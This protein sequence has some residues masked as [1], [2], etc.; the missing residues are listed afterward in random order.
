MNYEED[1]RIDESALDVE[2]LNQPGLFMK[3][4]RHLA[5]TRKILDE[6]KQKLDVTRAEV[7]KAI[8][9][10][11]EAC[12]IIKVTEGSI[13]SAII[14]NSDYTEA[15]QEYLN[16]KYETDMAQGAVN[17]F[18]QRKDAL[19]NLV[20]LNGQQYFAG[21]RVPR[22]LAQARKEKERKVDSG[23]GNKLSRRTR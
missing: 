5:E 4:S 13:Q 6:T 8:R 11:P 17:A 16:S 21:P 14:T 3:Y 2:W 23:I 12:G 15:Y 10:N 22:D 19:E 1:I 9:K 7:D 20:R 18:N